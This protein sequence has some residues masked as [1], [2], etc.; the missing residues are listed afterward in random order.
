MIAPFRTERLTNGPDY[1]GGGCGGVK[2]YKV[3]AER[4]E[5]VE[6]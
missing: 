3:E 2:M 5:E 1:S 4:E 6:S